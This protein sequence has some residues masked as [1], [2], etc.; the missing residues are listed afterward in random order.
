MGVAAAPLPPTVAWR[1]PGGVGVN[2]Q[3][4][5]A[6]SLLLLFWGKAQRSC[7]SLQDQWPLTHVGDTL[8]MG[9]GTESS[10]EAGVGT[11]P[12]PRVLGLWHTPMNADT[13]T[14]LTQAQ[15]CV[16]GPF[17]VLVLAFFCRLPPL[18]PDNNRGR[19]NIGGSQ[20]SSR[21]CG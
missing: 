17:G 15:L 11:C 8:Q 16:A 4:Q 12:R 21:K 14:I 1:R 3:L 7:L 2:Q 13:R 20:K 18:Q 6:F 10:V 5:S 9:H 19:L